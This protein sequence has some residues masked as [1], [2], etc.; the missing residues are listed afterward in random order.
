MTDMDL[1]TGLPE[2]LKQCIAFHGHFCPGLAYGYLVAKGAETYL[3][4]SRS[5][6]EEVVAICENDSCAVDALQQLLGT[7]FGK[8]N[9]VFQDYGKNA[10]TIYSRNSGKAFRF[11]R[12]TGY[13][14]EGKNPDEYDVLA[15]GFSDGALNPEQQA[16]YKYLKGRDLALKP[17]E[18]VFDVREVKF[19]PPPFAPLAPSMPCAVCGELTMQTKM[20]E[21]GAGDF[22][23]RPCA[24][25]QEL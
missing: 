7:T 19:E 16:R 22:L 20:T 25:R 5:S 4:L 17:C 15:S 12:K 2:D 6:D 21:T 8:G 11:C 23:C 14:Y 9:L 10:F 24:D 3:G 1:E 18:K 13:V